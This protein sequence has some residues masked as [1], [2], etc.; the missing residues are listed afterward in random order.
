MACSP[1]GL[2]RL[3]DRKLSPVGMHKGQGLIPGQAEIFFRLFFSRFGCSFYC[4]DHVHF[5]TVDF[6]FRTDEPDLFLSGL[7]FDYLE[8]YGLLM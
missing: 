5:L 6:S 2:F 7:L 8:V 3:M 1:V 4:E